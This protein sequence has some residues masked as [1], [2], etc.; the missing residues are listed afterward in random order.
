MPLKRMKLLP[1][2]EIIWH[3]R[4]LQDLETLFL[5]EIRNECSDENAFL[6]VISHLNSGM[7]DCFFICSSELV[8]KNTILMRPFHTR[9]LF[10][11][12]IHGVRHKK[13][14]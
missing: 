2:K 12:Q 3:T 11:I 4:V 6:F 9:W 13:T 10:F 5:G 14:F 8:T 7:F 1:L